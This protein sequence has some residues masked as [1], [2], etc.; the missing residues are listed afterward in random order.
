[1]GMMSRVI[2]AL[3]KG[4]VVL[5]F[6][7]ITQVVYL[8]MVFTTLPHLRGLA[9]GINPF[10][11][12][13]GGYDVDYAIHFL[14]AIGP[15]GRAFYLTRQIPLDLIYPGL[16]SITYAIVWRWFYAK[17]FTLPSMLLAGTL[18]PILAGLSDYAENG[19][20]IAMITKFPELSETLVTTA[21]ILTITKSVASTIYFMLL[22]GLVVTI[23]IQKLRGKNSDFRTS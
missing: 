3:T 16:F 9:G 1:M 4:R 14:E 22:L 15:G 23:G 19:L 13:P 10:D 11:M 18:L 8:V 7:V 5:G 17:L 6:F 21:S 20:I 12:S 2:A